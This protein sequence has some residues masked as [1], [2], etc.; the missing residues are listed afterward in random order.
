MTSLKERKR[1]I[2]T[3]ATK[4]TAPSSKLFPPPTCE[5]VPQLRQVGPAGGGGGRAGARLV[6]GHH[7]ADARLHREQPRLDEQGHDALRRVRVD[8]QLL[9]QRP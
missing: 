7:R 1:K 3:R 5:P 8:L 2:V 9:A 4:P 6:R